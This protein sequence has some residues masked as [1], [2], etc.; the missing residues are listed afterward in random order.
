MLGDIELD[1]A[2]CATANETVRATRTYTAADDGLAQPWAGT[3]WL[4]P[5]YGR[6]AGS[7]VAK[8]LHHH[9]NSDVPAA[10]ALLN[11]NSMEARWFQPLY[12][13]PL[14]LVAGRIDFETPDGK[15]STATHGSVFVY[16]GPDRQRFAEVFGPF[17]SILGRL[18]G[19]ADRAAS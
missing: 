12:E 19:T 18:H 14:C 13:H 7:F 15:A 16:L 6:Q 1:P 11:S 17:G 10:I 3:V 2:T 8:L 5:P 4:N 9:D